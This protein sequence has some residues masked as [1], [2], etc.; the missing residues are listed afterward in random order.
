M[1]KYDNLTPAQ[2]SKAVKEWLMPVVDGKRS[3]Q[4]ATAARLQG[5]LNMMAI[6]IDIAR[7]A[8]TSIPPATS[9]SSAPERLLLIANIDGFAQYILDKLE[10]V[11]LFIERGMGEQSTAEIFFCVTSPLIMGWDGNA[12]CTGVD[13]EQKTRH[14]AEVGEPLRLLRQAEELGAFVDT[15]TFSK[16]AEYVLESSVEL[17]ETVGRSVVAT[18]KAVDEALTGLAKDIFGRQLKTTAIA[19][20]LLGVGAVAYFGLR[21][22]R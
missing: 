5:L 17:A 20:G 7:A 6:Q 13:P 3:A 16:F 14:V 4:Y 11:N 22:R 9:M 15:Q 1:A 8:A 10:I 2:Y 19:L 12:D 21:K 18:A